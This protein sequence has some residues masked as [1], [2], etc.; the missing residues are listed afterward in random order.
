MNK[1]FI[2]YVCAPVFTLLVFS[3]MVISSQYQTTQLEETCVEAERVQT[4]EENRLN[5]CRSSGCCTETGEVLQ[6][7]L[8]D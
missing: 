5:W 7:C 2:A 6:G 4:E 1:F 8:D 3:M